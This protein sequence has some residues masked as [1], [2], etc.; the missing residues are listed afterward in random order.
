[1]KHLL[2]L[3]ALLRNRCQWLLVAF[4]IF[5]SL[6]AQSQLPTAQQ[7]A[8]QMKVGWNLGNTLE[9]ICGENAWGNPNTT[10]AL[11]NSV[12]AAGFNVVRI[13]CAWDCHTNNG[14]IDAAWIA[15]VKT[16]VDYCISNNMYVILNIHWDG[17]WL[18]NNCT[19]SA[20]TAVNA[21]QQNYWTQIATYFKNYDERLLF[22]SANE[23]AVSDAT[24]MAVLLSYHQTF[25]NAVR[26]TGGNN[27]SRSLI[28][29][30]P[31]TNIDNTYNLMNTMPTDQTANRLMV[32]VH[33]YVPWQFCGLT[34]DASWGTMFY[35]WGNGYHSTTQPDRNSTWGEES[36]VERALGLMKTKFVDKGI[37]VIIGEYGAI[38]RSNPADLSTHLASR[39]YFNKYVTSSSRNK[40]MVPVYWDNGAADFGIFNRTTAAVSDQGVVNAIMQ[41]AGGSTAG[42]ITIVN[43]ATGLLID[44]MGRTTNG[45]NC[46]QWSNS[47]SYNQQWTVEP[48]GS[49]IKL[50]NRASGLYLDG[51]GSNT[52]GAVAGQWSSSSSYNQQWTLENTGSFV[53][54]K[55]RASG[56]YLDGLGQTGNGS[57]LAQWSTSS[58]YNQQWTTTGLANTSVTTASLS[59]VLTSDANANQPTWQ[60]TIYPNP[61]ASTFSLEVD[62]KKKITLIEVIDMT[63]KVV[64]SI[65][66]VANKNR[67]VFGGALSPNTYIVKVS[68]NAGT[69]ST[70]II[71]Q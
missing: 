10:Q 55:N 3:S 12:K 65:K 22:A 20:Q 2:L 8:G 23:P 43:R 30:G 15:R 44:G 11:I 38:K 66:P 18:E 63:G 1:M 32:E 40:G 35:Y 47:G 24:G 46:S 14:V 16:V 54:I 53:K 51:M 59:P 5:I 68:G 6:P 9:A 57:D 13:P 64:E 25:I 71:K 49:Y 60:I 28:I 7:V 56:L 27:S 52:N 61:S 31:S 37:P 17:G 67:Y 19:T 34:A 69:T 39:E 41:G 70:K 45:S 62:N 21:K 42:Y 33:Y 29:Q 48:T 58:S 4:Y 36:E 50:K 26:A